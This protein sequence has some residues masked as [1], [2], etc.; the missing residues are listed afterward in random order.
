MLAFRLDDSLDTDYLG[1]VIVCADVAA[2]EA[3]RRG[4]DTRA[5][6]YL[7]VVH[8]LLHLLGWDDSTA[9][10]RAAM[11]RRARRIVR[12]FLETAR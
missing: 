9:S 1:E 10:T 6:L 4:L 2:D 3:A 12:D 8:G 11:N 5:E 7:Y